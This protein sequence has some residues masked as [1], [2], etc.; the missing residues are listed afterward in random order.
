MKANRRQVVLGG[1]A[2]ALFPIQAWGNSYPSKPISLIVHVP[3]GGGPDILARLLAGHLSQSIGQPMIVENR[4]GAG[5]SISLLT[6]ARSEPDGHTLLLAALP[7]V[8][9]TP[10]YQNLKISLVKDIDAIIGVAD[11]PF[12][13]LVSNKLPVSDVKEFIAYAQN[14]PGKLN[15]ASAGTGNLGHLAGELFVLS[16]KLK[17]QHVPYKGAPGV[18]T[19]LIAG[20]AHFAFD[21]VI[22]AKP[23]IESGS[24][25]AL[26][27]TSAKPNSSMPSLT[28]LDEFIPGYTVSGW[29]G[30]GAPKGTPTAVIDRLN[31]EVS[32]VLE[33]PKV[34]QSISSLGSDVM[35]GGISDFQRFVVEETKKWSRVGL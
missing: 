1:S 28:T 10:L 19:A 2:S 15:M 30:L 9:N 35:G 27:I 25:R 12:V 6:V 24:L 11:A 22:S 4:P 8:I 5:G 26:A 16:T 18:H 31:K 34:R 13:F 32:I 20:E 17:V 3:P 21:A 29:V 7:H 23:H 33:H 14:N